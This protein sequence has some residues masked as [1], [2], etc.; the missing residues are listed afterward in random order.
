MANGVLGRYEEIY[1][2]LLQGPHVKQAH[3]VAALL[4]IAASIDD[5]VTQVES[6]RQEAS[7]AAQ[8]YWIV[9]LPDND[10]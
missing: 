6:L 7:R 4:T 8:L 3:D 2:E 9:N 10:E 1:N 5:L